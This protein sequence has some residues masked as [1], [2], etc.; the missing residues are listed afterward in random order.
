[1]TQ[2]TREKKMEARLQAALFPTFLKIINDSAAHAG[3]AGAAT[4]LGHYTIEI[5]SAAFEGISLLAA[6]RLVYGALGDMMQT[7]IHA[8]SIN[9]QY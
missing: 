5:S 1:M 4:G 8:L 9:I 7:D 3:H 6:H 2:L